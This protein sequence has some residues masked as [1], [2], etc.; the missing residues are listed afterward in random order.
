MRYHYMLSFFLI[1][2]AFLLLN[3]FT[4]LYC[5]DYT[6]AFC[7][8]E[9]G[10]DFSR[11]IAGLVDVVV[12]QYHHYIHS[13]GRIIEIGLDQWFLGMRCKPV[14]DVCNTLVFMGYI[15][16]LLKVS[17]RQHWVY[18]WFVFLILVV[19]VRAFGEVFLWMTGCLNYLWAG[20][21]NLA[22]LMMYASKK[23]FHPIILCLLA[24]V[25]GWWQE[26]FS[27]GISGALLLTIV[28]RKYYRHDMDRQQLLMAGAYIVGTLLIIASPGNMGRCDDEG[29]FSNYFVENYWRNVLYVLLGLR[30]FWIFVVTAVVQKLRH[31]IGWRQV[32]K[33]NHFLLI[34]IGVEMLFLIVLGPIAQPRA[35]FGVETLSLVL[36]LRLLPAIEKKP[37][38][39]LMVLLS[40]GTYLPV[41]QLTWKNHQ[42]TQDFL[43]LVS[44]SDGTVF[45]DLPHYSHTERHYLGSFLVTDHRSRLFQQEAA[46]YGKQRLMVLPKRM[47][48]ELYLTSSFIC[49]EHL[50]H[51]GEYTVPDITFTI[52]P[53]PKNQPLPQPS[54]GCEY[55]S[56]PSGNYMLKDKSYLHEGLW[57]TRR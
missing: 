56:F 39:L 26:C 53:L 30:V 54:E 14:F 51:E 40:L 17:D 27:I 19:A 4:W 34:A 18:T 37:V 47:K 32:G 5:D 21:F 52:K 13:H 50:T 22:F 23:Q 28:Y 25:A 15:W 42:N 45:Y 41:L 46:Y 20:F 57:V 44:L 29:L 1:G 24:L 48:Q 9:Q 11:P 3:L 35:F 49:P 16:L 36:L 2:T 10:V 33:D 38:P 8:T 55:V 31:R 6:Y 7:L 12:S 43:A